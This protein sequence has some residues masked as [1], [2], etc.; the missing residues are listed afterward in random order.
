[1]QAMRAELLAA[2]VAAGPFAAAVP[3]TTPIVRKPAPQRAWCS[4]CLDAIAEP[5]SNFCSGCRFP[6]SAARGGPIVDHRLAD[7][8]LQ[9]AS[10]WPAPG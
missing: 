2:A 9:D 3:A 7:Q 4:V 8:D 5:S 1:M 10:A 6:H